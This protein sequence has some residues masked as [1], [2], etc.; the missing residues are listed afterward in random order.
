MPRPVV[1]TVAQ[2]ANDREPR[3]A[4]AAVRAG[5]AFCRDG[6]RAD[7]DTFQRPPSA[8][9]ANRKRLRRFLHPIRSPLL[10]AITLLIVALIATPARCQ[11]TDP[12]AGD[13][14]DG[15]SS[16]FRWS[17][18]GGDAAAQETL[19]R[20]EMMGPGQPVERIAISA[21][22][23]T[24]VYYF[25]PISP[26]AVIEESACKVMVRAARPGVQVFF[27]VALPRTL[28]RRTGNPLALLVPGEVL[29]VAGAW[30]DLRVAEVPLGLER[31]IRPL[32]L[33]L[34][35]LSIDPRGAVING[36]V[37]NVYGGPGENEVWI[38]DVSLSGRVAP[39]A[40]GDGGGPPPPAPPVG[41]AAPNGSPG[42]FAPRDP[43]T[44][45]PSDGNVLPA[46][47]W[48]NTPF[49]EETPPLTTVIR[50]D[51]AGSADAASPRT[52][53]ALEGSLLRIDGQPFF[54]RGVEHRGEPLDFLQRL[55]FNAVWTQ[56]ASESLLREARDR[57]MWVITRP[58][59][60]FLSATGTPGFERTPG[61]LLE[62][63]L[64]WDLGEQNSAAD[65]TALRQ[66]ADELRRRDGTTGR[67]LAARPQTD[68]R[69]VGRA[70]D[71]LMFGR[72]PAYTALTFR[73][74]A[75]WLRGRLLLPRPGTPAW[76]TVQ[77]QPDPALVDQWRAAGIDTTD[78]DG[79][80]PEQIRILTYLSLTAGAR[81][82]IY[83]SR[84]PLDAADRASRLRAAAMELANRELALVEPFLS[85]GQFVGMV[86]SNRPEITAAL[87]RTDR[88]RLLIPLWIGPGS[89]LVPGQSAS[90]DVAFVVP[91][92]PD[93]YSAYFLLPGNMAPL[94]A[95][96]VTGGMRVRLSECGPASLVVLTQDSLV[97]HHLSQRGSVSATRV[98]E[99][100]K[101]IA[102]DTLRQVRA[103][104]E[105]TARSGNPPA[106]AE[107]WFRMSADSLQAG[108]AAQ[109][110]GDA[111]DAIRQYQRAI[112]PP[113]LLR[114]VLWESVLDP[115]ADP[116]TDPLT[117]SFQTLPWY[118]AWRDR[119]AAA[120][121]GDNLL[122]GGDMESAEAWSSTGWQVYQY[123]V[124]GAESR[125]R[126]SASAARSGNL[127]LCL[128]ALPSDPQRPAVNVES[129]PIWCESPPVAVQA[130][131]LVRIEGWVYISRPMSGS[132]DGL[133][134]Q[135]SIGG[136]ALAARIPRTVGWRPFRLD[137]AATQSGELRL[138][139]LMTG[140]GEA[141]LDDLVIR[142]AK[143][144]GPLAGRPAVRSVAQTAPAGE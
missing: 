11:L 131:D 77:T 14:S 29:R 18:A 39:P 9:S 22:V 12:A 143:P 85:G 105:Q 141:C 4:V 106:N 127:G 55:G 116:T 109:R 144:L 46:A 137:R 80:E 43:F 1:I 69:A 41:I 120:A 130:G 5:A 21:G 7:W 20:I 78:I 70:V 95:E 51:S 31:E 93:A 101:E 104:Y 111:A 138:R 129:P 114:R 86:E 135:D 117:L 98:A 45:P 126:L 96:R 47:G 100:W 66:A 139:I 88:A 87:F 15:A 32:R 28:D 61:P 62:P 54:V 17:Y 30:T 35:G 115:A 24:A 136:D 16:S 10:A 44:S 90:Q 42:A 49:A 118:L 89:Q 68:L 102:S 56:Q 140:L 71:I 52:R 25:H 59:P 121:W 122:P 37:L 19:H 48:S 99:L 84:S 53:I 2:C 73:D 63:I 74:Y 13:P 103:V 72:E 75:D 91:G 23:G 132:P 119:C 60:A 33:Q 76:V 123:P 79:L 57:G 142:T 92:V 113:A 8:H 58:D 83:R 81:G 134:I 64:A 110:R 27:S 108:D 6:R 107:A 128:S 124:P 34:G 36:I 133:V 94:D 38:G 125:A 26:A 97:L 50:G 112:R 65:V 3:L 67:L 40:I 82:L